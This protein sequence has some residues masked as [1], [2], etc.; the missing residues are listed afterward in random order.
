MGVRESLL[1]E[2]ASS[3]ANDLSRMESRLPFLPADAGRWVGEMEE[4]ARRIRDVAV[5]DGL[6][7]GAA[8]IF[9]VSAR[10]P[11]AEETREN[12]DTSRTLE[13]IFFIYAAHLENKNN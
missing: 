13:D 12:I 11:Y 4:I 10:T 7:E 1:D 3:Q 5:P 8:D 9:R 2:F 6:H